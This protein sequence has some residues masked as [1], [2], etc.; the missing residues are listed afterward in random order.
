[1]KIRG[2]RGRRGSHGR[3][4][5][6]AA[7]PQALDWPAAGRKR[8]CP[9]PC[10]THCRTGKKMRANHPANSV[11]RVVK[12]RWLCR[13]RWTRPGQRQALAGTSAASPEQT[14]LW[15]Q[16]TSVGGGAFEK[17]ES[18]GRGFFE[19]GAGRR[20]KSHSWRWN[21]LETRNLDNSTAPTGSNRIKPN[22]TK[23]NQ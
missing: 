19:P 12:C 22:Q 21:M 6:G 18:S 23:S 10:E 15:A 7:V 2:H 1:M 16:T 3:G 17:P 8:V 4:G 13:L 14:I 9:L 5:C 20:L 11:R